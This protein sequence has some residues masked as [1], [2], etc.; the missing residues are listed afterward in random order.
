MINVVKSGGKMPRSVAF[1]MDGNRRYAVKNKQEKHQGHSAG[2]KKLEQ[3]LI[4]CKGL[5][6]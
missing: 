1:I 2:L 6:I 5:G 4:W 3:A